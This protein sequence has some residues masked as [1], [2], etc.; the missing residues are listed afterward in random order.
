MNQGEEREGKGVRG[1]ERGERSE[2]WVRGE[3]GGSKGSGGMGVRGAG[4]KEFRE[5]E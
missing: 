4:E 2:E 5:G 1:E 3:W